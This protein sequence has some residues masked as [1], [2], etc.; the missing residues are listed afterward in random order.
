MTE[1]KNESANTEGF[2]DGSA[3]E[4]NSCRDMTLVTEDRTLQED[5]V[6]ITEN[7]E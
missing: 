2:N 1:A 4:N 3:N 7:K 5:I 6:H